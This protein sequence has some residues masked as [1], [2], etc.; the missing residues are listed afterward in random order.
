MLIS[1]PSIENLGKYSKMI[2]HLHTHTITKARH[3]RTLAALYR[4]LSRPGDI[5]GPRV[6]VDATIDS[7]SI[8]FWQVK[9]PRIRY[10]VKTSLQDAIMWRDWF[11]AVYHLLGKEGYRGADR[12]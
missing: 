3:S 8:R 9:E 2:A 10:E 6:E 7:A 4:P 12:K 1:E 11:S 5:H